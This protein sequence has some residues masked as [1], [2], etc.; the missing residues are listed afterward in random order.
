MLSAT[1]ATQEHYRVSLGRVKPQNTSG[2]NIIHIHTKKGHNKTKRINSSNIG[3][4]P[5]LFPNNS[6][7]INISLI[8]FLLTQPKNIQRNTVS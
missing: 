2:S 6:S 7:F 5:P 4:L 1:M 3:L 8:G